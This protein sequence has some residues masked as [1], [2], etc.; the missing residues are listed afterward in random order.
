MRYTPRA[1][2]KSPTDLVIASLILMIAAMLLMRIEFRRTHPAPPPERIGLEA[3]IREL[4]E[5]G[6]V[7]HGYKPGRMESLQA[8]KGSPQTGWD[9]ALD[10]ILAAEAGELEKARA[11]ALE[12]SLPPG[13]AGAPFRR[14][15]VAAYLGEGA[16]PAPSEREA[17][18]H[19]LRQGY[20]A[21]L[22]E[23]RLRERSG[24]PA[25][26]L[27][28]EARAWAGYRARWLALSAFLVGLALV[29]GL[30]FAVALGFTWHR[31][32]AAESPAVAL[33]F[34]SMVIALLGWFLAF[35][36]SG[37]IIGM[38]AGI[39]PFLKPMA[40]HLAYLFHAW[41]ALALLSRL[42]GMTC[43]EYLRSLLRGTRWLHLAWGAGFAVLA[44]AA[45][46]LTS[47]ALSPILRGQDPPQRE[48]MDLMTGT[49]QTWRLVSFFILAAGMAPL[50][51]EILFR[52]S[53]LPWLGHRLQGR[54]G[55]RWGWPLALGISALAFGAIHLEPMALP[56]LSVLGCILGLAVLRTGSLAT[57]IVVHGIWNGGV[58]VFYRILMG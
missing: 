56:V 26:A 30:G 36:L 54:V 22:L 15:W 53:L 3:R 27:R 35:L 29:G 51:E 8:P 24:L 14:C 7:I 58:L 25:Q 11:L 45:V 46:L 12:A 33:P 21:R 43:M 16:M 2:F 37:T 39:L 31:A 52:G 50:F 34:R 44:L 1:L 47:L 19:A 41:V 57:S 4:Q 28:L 18:A 38:L 48:L 10:A 5:A 55:A 17:V 23:A 42:R 49:S 32:P 40:F 9:R 20:A 6:R 13:P